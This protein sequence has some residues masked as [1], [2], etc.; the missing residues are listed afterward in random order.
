MPGC[1][2]SGFGFTA[3]GKYLMPQGPFVEERHT[4]ASTSEERD[5]ISA[6]LVERTA[7]VVKR[8][9]VWVASLPPPRASSGS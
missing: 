3:W 7:V 1:S 4:L 6:A 9:K 5:S 8:R 2:P